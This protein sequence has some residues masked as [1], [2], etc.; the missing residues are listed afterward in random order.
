MKAAAE[1]K[2]PLAQ[3]LVGDLYERGVGVT[4]DDSQALH[5]Y[6]MAVGQGEPLEK[7]KL[8]AMEKIPLKR[9]PM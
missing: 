4:K 5:Y 7:K 3:T 9:D 6:L 2:S 8:A 1:D